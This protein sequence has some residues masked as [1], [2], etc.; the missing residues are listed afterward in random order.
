MAAAGYY[1]HRPLMVGMVYSGRP[2]RGM[3]PQAAARMFAS[4]PVPPTQPISLPVPSWSDCYS[5]SGSGITSANSRWIQYQLELTTSDPSVSPVLNEIR[6][7]YLAPATTTIP[8]TTT[9]STVEPTTSIPVPSCAGVAPASAG[10]GAT[11]DVTITGLSTNFFNSVTVASF[12]GTGITVISTVVTSPTQAVATITVDPDATLEARDVTATTGTEMVTCPAAFTITAAQVTTTTTVPVTTIL[13]TTTTTLGQTWTQTDWAGGAGQSLWADAR[14][15]D[16]ATGIDTSVA[17]QISLAS[18]SSALFTDDFSRTD[19]LPW[20][21][22]MGTWTITG[23]VL[24]GSGAPNN[25]SYASY[26]TTPQQW[27]DYMVQGSI[28]IP[29]GSFGGGIGGRVDP[30]TGAHYGAWVYP[31]ESAGGSNMLKLWKFQGWTDVGSGVPMHQVSLPEVGTGWHT[32]QMTFIG[33]RIL[34]YY[35]GVLQ[36]DVTDDNS[37]YVSGGISAD[38]YS[39][40]LLHTIAVDNISVTTLPY[41]SSG[42]LSSSAFDG[43]DGVQ[44]QTVSWDAA[45]GGSTNVCVRTRTADAADQLASAPWSDCYSTS[46]SGITSANSRWIQYQLELTTSDP[47]VSPVLNE[48]R[49]GY[50][51]PATTSI[52]DTTT[53]LSTTTTSTI[54]STT[55]IPSPGCA[56]VAPASADQGATLDVTITGVDTSFVNGVTVASFSGTGITVNSTLVNSPAQAVANIT[57]A[58]D[59]PVGACDVTVTTGT[60]IV[61][62]TAAF[63]ITAAP[64]TTT[65]STVE[66]TTTIAPCAD[67][68]ADGVCNDVDNCPNQANGPSLGTCMPGS[69]KEGATCHSDADCVIGC[70]GNGKCAMNQEPDVCAPPTTTTIEPTTT[71]TTITTDSDGD[72]V[73]DTED[74]CPQKPNGSLLGTCTPG[75]DKAGATCTSDADCVIGCSINGTCSKNQ[76]DTDSDG[77]GDVCDNCPTDCNPLQLDANNNGIGDLCDPDPGCG[78]MCTATV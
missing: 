51:A 7:G 8:D 12:S 55:T 10:Q 67:S 3:Q 25:Y 60:E 19:L 42:V 9:T 17:G 45:A 15:Y 16:S 29:A 56:G 31:A 71:T 75:S 72:G 32:L 46:G 61:T 4:G 20:V 65:T 70:S 58:S 1:H 30:A 11:L 14:R 43:G 38:W 47:S 59:A 36:I 34:V 48:I 77:A 26:S 23:E 74:N 35:D 66:P 33:N 54:E 50:L 21:S 2:Y 37:P 73:I 68:D 53:T 57:I 18:T 5:T 41:G 69:D 76:E 78:G 40:S 39:G 44:W 62:C 52:P 28:Q 49:I 27:T 13:P 64:V 24:Q 63:T 22:P 6:I